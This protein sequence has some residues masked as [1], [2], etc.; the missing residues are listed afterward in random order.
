MAS[1]KPRTGK[2]IEC[3]H[4]SKE[5]YVPKN[6]V[7]TAKFCSRSCL[8]LHARE[9]VESEC[10]VCGK[11][12]EH[13]SS[14]ANKAKY[15]SRTCYHKAQAQKGSVTSECRH[16]GKSFQHAPSVD[17]KYCSRACVNKESKKTFKGKFTTIRRMMERRGMIE[18]C[19][20]CGYKEHPE[21]L[22]VHH[23]DRNRQNNE[24]S[25]LEV[26]CPNCHSLEHNKHVCH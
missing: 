4:C 3:A 8:A 2:V 14:R 25:N 22:G 26:L 12:F 16:C 7:E 19:E 15:C 24:L 9:R 5:F 11:P 6:R 17:R 21:I 1:K 20:R 18:A 23:K 10:E 13:I